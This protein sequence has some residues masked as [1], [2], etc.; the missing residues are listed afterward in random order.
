MPIPADHYDLAVEQQSLDPDSLLN[1]WRRL[2]HWRQQQPALKAGNFEL[3]DAN[4]AILAFTR[5]YA[6]Q[7][8]LCVFNVSETSQE[9]DISDDANC[10]GL[11]LGFPVCRDGHTVTLPAYGVFFGEIQ[12]S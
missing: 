3:Q 5:G 2:L 4:D 12:M 8:L 1:V 7:K 9:Y 6:E 10:K 11:S